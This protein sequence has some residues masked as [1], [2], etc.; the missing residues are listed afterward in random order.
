MRGWWLYWRRDDL[1]HVRSQC[2]P[3]NLLNANKSPYGIISNP[4]IEG[5]HRFILELVKRFI[6]RR[7]RGG[8][9]ERLRD[10]IGEGYK[11]KKL[12][13]ART[14]SP[15]AVATTSANSTALHSRTLTPRRSFPW[16]LNASILSQVPSFVKIRT[17]SSSFCSLSRLARKA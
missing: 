14:G 3:A 6:A 16:A 7:A 2:C 17:I 4:H 9:P 5:D 11:V 8:T 12:P 10:L 13:S 15:V 1:R